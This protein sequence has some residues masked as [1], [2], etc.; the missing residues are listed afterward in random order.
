ML[1]L[2]KW[3]YSKIEKVNNLSDGIALFEL[4]E[5]HIFHVL[6]NMHNLKGL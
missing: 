5:V 3:Y 6:L 4:S 2:T 1:F